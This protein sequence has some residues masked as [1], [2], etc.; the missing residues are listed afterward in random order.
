M[1]N[2]AGVC[3]S[4]DR[5]WFYLKKLT[6]ESNFLDV[7]RSLRCIFVYDNLNIHH[8]ARHE[9]DSKYTCACVTTSVPYM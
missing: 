3:L 2:H 8:V 9:R 5:I 1:L 4:Y 6:Q 7:I